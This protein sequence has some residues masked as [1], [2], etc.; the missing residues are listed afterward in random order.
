MH[1]TQHLI[2]LGRG[3]TETA[4]PLKPQSIRNDLEQ[5]SSLAPQ[6]PALSLHV[7]GLW[8]RAQPTSESRQFIMEWQL[9]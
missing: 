9:A 8:F 4:H 2:W 1:S 6:P 3:W 5:R 7:D